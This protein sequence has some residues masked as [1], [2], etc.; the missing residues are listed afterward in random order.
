MED[1]KHRIAINMIQETDG[2]I[3]NETLMEEFSD[4]SVVHV[5]K[6]Q[7]FVDCFTRA[8]SEAVQQLSDAALDAM[9]GEDR[10]QRKKK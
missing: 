1:R 10:P 7:V 3:D 2:V 9:V 8:I 6:T 5:I 4:D